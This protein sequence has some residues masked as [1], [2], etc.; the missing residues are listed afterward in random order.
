MHCHPEKTEFKDRKRQTGEER[1][2][3][4]KYEKKKNNTIAQPTK[5]STNR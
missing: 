3:R 2:E 4:E 5:K 1:K